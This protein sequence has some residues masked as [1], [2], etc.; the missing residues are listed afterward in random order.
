LPG[1]NDKFNN[2]G[3]INVDV[4]TAAAAA[5]AAAALFDTFNFFK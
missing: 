4:L 1:N 3:F 2:D 5:A